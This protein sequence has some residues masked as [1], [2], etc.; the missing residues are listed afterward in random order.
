MFCV[1][2]CIYI[3]CEC[4]LSWMSIVV[5][6]LIYYSFYRNL[7]FHAEN[8]F[9]ID[10]FG[11]P[12]WMSFCLLFKFNRIILFFLAHLE[13]H[14]FFSLFVWLVFF[15]LFLRNK[16]YFRQWFYSQVLIDFWEMNA[17]MRVRARVCVGKNVNWISYKYFREQHTHTTD[18][19]IQSAFYIINLFILYFI[20]VMQ[21]CDEWCVRNEIWIAV[22]TK[23]EGER[24][25]TRKANNEWKREK[26]KNNDNQERC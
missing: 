5:F 2:E 15:L 18:F 26:K 23:R 6:S 16:C 24:E 11:W 1:F 3:Y 4:E 14:P 12:F 22:E 21:I 7:F 25:R 10:F 20:F 19:C 13:L 8:F 17:R 9:Q